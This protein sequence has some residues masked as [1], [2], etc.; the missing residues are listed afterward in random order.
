MDT[1]E[2]MVSGGGTQYGVPLAYV[3][4]RPHR[5]IVWKEKVI[6]HVE[7]TCCLIRAFE[8]TSELVEKPPFVPVESAL[9]DPRVGL[10]GLLYGGA[11]TCQAGFCQIFPLQVSECIEEDIELGPHLCGDEGPQGSGVRAAGIHSRDNR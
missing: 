2:C 9:R 3:K 10:A 7:Q 4:W 6:L 1:T 5:F 11:E 8:T